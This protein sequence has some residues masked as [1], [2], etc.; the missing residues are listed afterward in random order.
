MIPIDS[1][2]IISPNFVFMDSDTYN[3]LS[4]I[5][6]IIIAIAMILTYCVYY[7][8]LKAMR[9]SY[10]TQN[11]ISIMKFLQEDETRGARESVIKNE[12]VIEKE[13]SL[14]CSSYH[15]LNILIEKENFISE[16][17]FIDNWKYSIV[18]CYKNSESHINDIQKDS[19]G[20]W[21]GFKK[22]YEKC[23]E[24]DPS[25]LPR[26]STDGIL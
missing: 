21:S 5:L 13:L 14:V 16:D 3:A 2:T 15:F 1:A 22:L 26:N 7:N 9:L 23:I 20:Q 8:Q 24:R 25:L 11:D 19:P 4:L 10:K 18:K 17:I 12:V 6:Q